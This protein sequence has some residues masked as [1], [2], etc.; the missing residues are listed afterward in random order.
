M[1]NTVFITGATGNIGGKIVTRLLEDDSLTRLIL[2]IRGRCNAEAGQRIE[3]VLKILSPKIDLPKVGRRIKVVCGD[4]TL[5]ELGLPKPIWRN[6]SSEIT[7]IIHAAATTQFQLP[8]EC[9]RLV[10]YTGT[11]NVMSF[12]RSVQ[13]TGN[14][15]GIA[16]IS[17]AFVWGDREGTIYEDELATQPRFSNSY[18]QTK[19]ESERFV[20]TL[21]QDLPLTIFRPSIVV[22]D[23]QTGRTITFNTLYTPLKYIHA[24]LLTTLPCP[25][26][27]PLDIVPLDFV[28]ES[29]LHIFMGNDQGNGKTYHIVAGMT[30]EVTVGEIVDFAIHYFNGGIAQIKFSVS[31]PANLEKVSQLIKVYEPYICAARH[32]DNNNTLQALKGTT[33]SVP[34]LSSYFS[35]LMEYCFSTDW[36]KRL[37]H[38]A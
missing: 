34:N 7:H 29:I 3:K 31:H 5:N 16:Y 9:A 6:L 10:N 36:G 15:K 26:D 23:S 18:E 35:H 21:M 11:K 20:R 38:A 28:S 14:L 22:G 32:F 24:G 17:T 4:I 12:A 30:K 19:W 1:A 8:L 27:N 25:P 37:K 33:I 13:E 2:L